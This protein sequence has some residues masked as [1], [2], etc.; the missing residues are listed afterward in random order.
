MA[1]AAAAKVALSLA[2]QPRRAFAGFGVCVIRRC[3]FQALPAFGY[4]SAGL[5]T[6]RE[7]ER[8]VHLGTRAGGGEE[9]KEKGVT[10]M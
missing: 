7:A 5:Q 10:F 1:A 6:V 8:G 4:P 9:R 2:T 3:C